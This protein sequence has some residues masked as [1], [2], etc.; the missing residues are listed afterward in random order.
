MDILVTG[1]QFYEL[2]GGIS[3]KN[4]AFFFFFSFLP[5]TF[6]K[7]CNQL[8]SDFRCRPPFIFNAF[9][10][11]LFIYAISFFAQFVIPAV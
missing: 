8:M 2:L 6:G 5:P 11:F 4:H 10:V 1:F 3:L 7:S 9:R